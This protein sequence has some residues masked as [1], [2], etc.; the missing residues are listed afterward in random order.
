MSQDIYNEI[1]IEWRTHLGG[2]GLSDHEITVSWDRG[3]PEDEPN[4]QSQEF[5]SWEEAEA[6]LLRQFRIPGGARDVQPAA[7]S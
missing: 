1:R 6:F 3:S 2:G 7:A 5:P 4:P